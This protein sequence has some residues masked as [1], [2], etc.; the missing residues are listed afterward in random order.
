MLCRG[1]QLNNT[2]AI[3]ALATSPGFHASQ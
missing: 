1:V 2:L 3:N